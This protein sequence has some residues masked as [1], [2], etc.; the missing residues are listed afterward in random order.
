MWWV[1]QTGA[2]VASLLYQTGSTLDLGGTGVG[3]A[4]SV[5]SALW[6]PDSVYFNYASVSSGNY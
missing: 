2:M 1:V 6:L 3:G 5:T 4:A